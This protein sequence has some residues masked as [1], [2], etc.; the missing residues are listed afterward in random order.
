M[1][2]GEFDADK[3]EEGGKASQTISNG[4]FFRRGN[5]YHIEEQ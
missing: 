5:I 2:L 4:K 1:P 3:I